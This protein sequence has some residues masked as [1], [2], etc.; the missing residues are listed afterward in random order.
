MQQI[1]GILFT[2][3]MKIAG[4]LVIFFWSRSL[5]QKKQ[6]NENADAAQGRVDV[7][8]DV[9]AMDPADRRRMFDEWTTTK[10]VPRLDEDSPRSE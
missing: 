4:P 7:I 10:P 5:E 2:L 1:I 9:A 3:V 6:A 8:A